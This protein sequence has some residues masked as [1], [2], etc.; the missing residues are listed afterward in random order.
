[1]KKIENLLVGVP[2]LGDIHHIDWDSHM[3]AAHPF[4]GLAWESGQAVDVDGP[5]ANLLMLDFDRLGVANLEK[6]VQAFYSDPGMES[7]SGYLVAGSE[8]V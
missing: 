4:E 3:V 2:Y 6:V 8:V 7:C 5:A 1:M